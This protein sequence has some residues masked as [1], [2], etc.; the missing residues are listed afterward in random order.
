M[1][2]E[3]KGKESE[4]CIWQRSTSK[5]SDPKKLG[6]LK[7]G[8]YAE[9]LFPKA[10]ATE[11]HRCLI[12]EK[13]WQCYMP[14]YL[15]D[16]NGIKPGSPCILPSFSSVELRHLWSACHKLG[17]LIMLLWCDFPLNLPRSMHRLSRAWYNSQGTGEHPLTTMEVRSGLS[18]ITASRVVEG[19]AAMGCLLLCTYL[20]LY[21]F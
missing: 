3:S 1:R 2:N 19:K 10:L 7:T 14:P 12:E 11:A 5:E 15:S 20:L 13:L 4:I 21:F 6:F 8:A 18:C 17:W 16:S 9:D